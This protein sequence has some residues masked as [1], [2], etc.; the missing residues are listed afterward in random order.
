MQTLIKI[1]ILVIKATLALLLLACNSTEDQLTNDWKV[2]KMERMVSVTADTQAPIN[3]TVHKKATYKLE[4]TKMAKIITQTGSKITG[5]W[6]VEDSILTIKTK[7]EQK[8]FTIDTLA[9]D[10][11]ILTSD[12]F[13]FYMGLD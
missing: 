8:R 5:S 7:E 4:S 9:V 3:I 12:R 11:L 13:K 2:R 6:Q 10:T 1:I